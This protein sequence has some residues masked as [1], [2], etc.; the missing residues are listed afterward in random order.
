MSGIATHHFKLFVVLWRFV[1]VMSAF[2]VIH[3]HGTWRG[4]G[5]P[6]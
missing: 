2:M 3:S 6:I 1:T 4:Q 5:L